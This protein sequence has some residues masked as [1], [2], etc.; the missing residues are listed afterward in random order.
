MTALIAASA[1]AGATWLLLRPLLVPVSLAAS[2]RPR[3]QPG[4]LGALAVAGGTSVVVLDGSRVVLGLVAVAVVGAG[5]RE[6]TRRRRVADAERRAEHVL[7]MCE[8][9]ASDLRAGQ[10]PVTALAA[11][12]EDWPELAPVAVAA[13]LGADVPDAL[14]RLGARPGAGQLRIVAAAWQVAHRSGAGLAAA[15]TMAA[16]RLRDDRA[17][18]RVL[19]TEMAAAQA[20]AR[21]LAV[22]PLAVL[23]LG[24]GLGGSPVGFL[25]DSTPGLVC[26]CTGLALEYAGLVWLARIADRVLGRR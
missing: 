11:A 14:R 21:L 8:G 5:A 25:L 3:S 17:T 1:A 24:S 15:L 23:A 18:A 2:G 6:L 26:L 10:P 20:T 4:L 7:T 16:Q 19:S 12:A 9:L 13:G 22:L